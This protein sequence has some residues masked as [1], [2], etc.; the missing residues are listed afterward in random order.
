MSGD[1][2]TLR[3]HMSTETLRRQNSTETLET[4]RR[5]GSYS[6]AAS[7]WFSRGSHNISQRSVGSARSDGDSEA[8]SKDSSIA[9]RVSRILPDLLRVVAPPL[10]G[11]AHEDSEVLLE[12]QRFIIRMREAQEAESLAEVKFSFDS[13]SLPNDKLPDLKRIVSRCVRFEKYRDMEDCIYPL[14]I[15]KEDTEPAPAPRQEEGPSA[16]MPV[17]TS[18]RRSISTMFMH[19]EPAPPPRER[20]GPSEDMPVDTSLRRSISTM[21]M[22]T[23]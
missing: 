15:V 13:Y 14:R 18:L 10:E 6:T 4:L 11:I 16:V 20:E 9:A 12:E 17:R 23:S 21:F 8:D 22:R 5:A 3:R 1:R 19:T 7:G 2:S